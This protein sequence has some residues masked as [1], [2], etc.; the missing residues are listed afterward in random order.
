MVRPVK[1]ETDGVVRLPAE[2]RKRLG[3]QAGDRLLLEEREGGMFLR[4]ETV[5]SEDAAVGQAGVELAP[6]VWP[7]EDFSAWAGHEG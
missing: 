4:A 6:R 1:I 5:P 2:V 3:W 7:N